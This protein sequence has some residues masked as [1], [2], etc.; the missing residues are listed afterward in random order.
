MGFRGPREWRQKAVQWSEKTRRAIVEQAV[1]PLTEVGEA[2]KRE[3]QTTIVSGNVG[4]PPLSASTT[5]RK[6]HDTKL[7]DSGGYANS[8][9]VKVSRGNPF[10]KRVDLTMICQPNDQYVAIGKAHEY[11]TGAI[12]ARP[13]WRPA[14]NAVQSSSEF[15]EFLSGKWFRLR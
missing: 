10:G 3:V 14:I 12:P 4:G 8:I 11:G 5:E 6:G 15:S 13:H 2:I 9:D 7:V 1:G